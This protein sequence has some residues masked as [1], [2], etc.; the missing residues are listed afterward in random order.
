[1]V[2]NGEVGTTVG[3]PD[4]DGCY[5]LYAIRN[6]RTGRLLT[7]EG[8]KIGDFDD[9][10]A[11][12]VSN[13]RETVETLLKAGAESIKGFGLVFLVHDSHDFDLVTMIGNVILSEYIE[14]M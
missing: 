12:F 4:E 6:R 5:K 1:M 13:T 11:V 8:A 9:L 7:I 3:M 10:N 2:D 14:E